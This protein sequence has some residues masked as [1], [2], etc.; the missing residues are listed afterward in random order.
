MKHVREQLESI[1]IEDI[2]AVDIDSLAM[3]L[4]EKSISAEIQVNK[5]NVVNNVQ[6]VV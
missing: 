5:E 1:K 2:P 3:D 6:I 4:I